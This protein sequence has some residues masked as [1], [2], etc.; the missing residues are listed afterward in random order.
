MFE[1]IMKI[2]KKTRKK[3]T[4]NK[5]GNKW[6]KLKSGAGWI[7]L[8]NK[9]ITQVNKAS[10][11]PTYTYLSNSNYNGT[12]IVIALKEIGVDSSFEYRKK[13]AQ[14]NNVRDY[15]GTAQQNNQLLSKLKAGKLKKA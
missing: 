14:K 11:I 6:G 9:Y 3:E 7:S 2:F 13:L 5:S 4:I 8:N 1:N 15:V 12:S 10:S